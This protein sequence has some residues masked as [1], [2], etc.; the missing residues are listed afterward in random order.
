MDSRAE[1]QVPIGPSRQIEPL[2]VRIGFRVEIGRRQHGHDPVPFPQPDPAELNVPSD[3]PGLGELHWRDE[4]QEL[5][6]GQRCAAPVLLEP[7]AQIGA[8]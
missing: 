8:S 1:G 2:R 7:V 4:A 3:E 5:L 6:D